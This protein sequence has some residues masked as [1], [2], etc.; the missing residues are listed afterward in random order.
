MMPRVQLV[1]CPD[2]REALA[3]AERAEAALARKSV[4]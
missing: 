1:R 3:R 4:V 2:C